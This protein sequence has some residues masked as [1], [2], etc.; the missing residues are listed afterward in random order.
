MTE[1]TLLEGFIFFCA[2]LALSIGAKKALFFIKNKKI[3]DVF[4]GIGIGGGAIRAV[5]AITPFAVLAI[6]FYVGY[7]IFKWYKGRTAKP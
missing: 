7:G 2:F 4:L 6:L 1:E 3:A 5:P